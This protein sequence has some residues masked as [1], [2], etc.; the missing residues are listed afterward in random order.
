M[1]TLRPEVRGYRH[2]FRV[3]AI[4]DLFWKENLEEGGEKPPAM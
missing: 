4:N 1:V 3:R 2:S